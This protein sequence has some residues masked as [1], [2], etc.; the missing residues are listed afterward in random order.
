MAT[1]NMSALIRNQRWADRS[2]HRLWIVYVSYVGEKHF[3][4]LIDIHGNAIAYSR[5]SDARH[6]AAQVRQMRGRGNV[7]MIEVTR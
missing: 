5:L 2:K 4:P 7:K 1:D 3:F 6:E